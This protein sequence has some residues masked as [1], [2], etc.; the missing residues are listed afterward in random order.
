MIAG[1]SA[2]PTKE[3]LLQFIMQDIRLLKESKKLHELVR[4]GK[5]SNKIQKQLMEFLE[6]SMI[7]TFSLEGHI[8]N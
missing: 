4:M 2:L 8:S 6:A 5:T 3:L 7:E 1:Y